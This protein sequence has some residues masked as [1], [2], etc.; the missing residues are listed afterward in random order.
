MEEFLETIKI[1]KKEIFNIKYHNNRLNK[2]IKEIYGI[3]SS[4]DLIDY[5]DIPSIEGSYRCRV[6]YTDTIKSIEYIPQP[7]IFVSVFAVF[8]SI[9]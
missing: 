2:T 7:K 6:V 8:I 9:F 3:D 4:I 5:I 1:E